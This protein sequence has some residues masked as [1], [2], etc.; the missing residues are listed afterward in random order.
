MNMVNNFNPLRGCKHFNNR[1]PG[2][3][4]GYWASSPQ[5][6][7]LPKI[8]Q[9]ANLL[10][11]GPLRHFLSGTIIFTPDVVWNPDSIAIGIEFKVLPG[12][13]EQALWHCLKVDNRNSSGCC[14]DENKRD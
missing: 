8:S 12:L 3:N 14:I 1:H 6:W 4:R 13:G 9:W 7:L 11:V 5:G 2:C 10:T